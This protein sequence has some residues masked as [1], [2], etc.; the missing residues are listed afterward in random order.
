MPDCTDRAFYYSNSYNWTSMSFACVLLLA[1]LICGGIFA[2]RI[3]T[4]VKQ[5]NC[6]YAG[7]FPRVLTLLARSQ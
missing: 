5:G 3:W 2:A 6:W 1:L 7:P 4:N